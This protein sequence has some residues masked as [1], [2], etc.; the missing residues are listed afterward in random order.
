M[1]LGKVTLNPSCLIKSKIKKCFLVSYHNSQCQKSWK[2]AYFNDVVI[3][4][5]FNILD[6]F[7]NILINQK[8]KVST[9]LT[10]MEVTTG[11]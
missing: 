5:L 11:K 1:S 6:H 9:T 4:P 2:Y 8:I 7:P 3:V 10:I